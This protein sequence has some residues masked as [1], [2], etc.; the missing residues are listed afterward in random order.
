MKIVRGDGDFSAAMADFVSVRLWGKPGCFERYRA[1]GVADDANRIVAALVYN[2]YHPDEGVIEMHGAADTSR[3]L[4]KSVLREM[5]SIP[6]E[7]IGCQLAVM[8]V[9]ERNKRLARMLPAYGFKA[10]RIPRLRGRDE[11][12]IIYTLA[13]D[14]WRANKFMKG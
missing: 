3:W 5:F 11:A 7:E 8:R 1:V 14:D 6:F 4:T 9:S 2:N 10:Y 13:D 12:E